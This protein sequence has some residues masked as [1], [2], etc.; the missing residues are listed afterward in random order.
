MEM[1]KKIVILTREIIFFIFFVTFPLN[2]PLIVDLMKIIVVAVK[3][4]GWASDDPND[5]GYG[6]G[7]VLAYLYFLY[8]FYIAH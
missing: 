7:I 6:I 2:A 3:G 4:Y 1:L 8:Y 5:S